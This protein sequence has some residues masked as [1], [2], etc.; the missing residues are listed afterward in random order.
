MARSVRKL[1][2]VGAT[3]AFLLI[4]GLNF[5]ALNMQWD[6]PYM[7]VQKAN[8]W[9]SC[10]FGICVQANGTNDSWVL[11][12]WRVT[13]DVISTCGNYCSGCYYP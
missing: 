11:G 9:S 2:L 1:G 12:C 13:T 8:A 4:A 7:G 3:L 10:V 5:T 6:V